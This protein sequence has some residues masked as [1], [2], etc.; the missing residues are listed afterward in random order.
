[1][2]RSSLL[3][4]AL[5]VALGTSGCQ[6]PNLTR[7]NFGRTAIVTGDFDTVRQLIQEVANTTT[8]EA[9]IHLFD[10]YIDGPH[11]ET[12]TDIEPGDLT[13]Q[14]EDLLRADTSQGL[15]QFD[16]TFLSCGMRGVS[17]HL[18]N[19][20][21]E[22]D[23]LVSDSTVLA[24]LQ[25]AL[26]HGGALYFSD[27]TYDLIQAA[28][29]DK[30]HWAGD[31]DELDDAQRGK[32]GA[33][34]A[35]VVSSELAAFM[36]LSVGDE[37]EIRFNQSGWAVPLSVADD[38]EVLI[39]ADIEYDNPV[40]GEYELREDVPLVFSFAGGGRVVYTAFHNEAQITDDAR[41]VLRFSLTRLSDAA[42]T[43]P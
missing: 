32:E 12:E 13:N 40:T 1:L 37:I 25:E 18:Y 33:V 42:S 14:V 9:D 36:E 39:E 15:D 6:D 38:V 35:R 43:S 4:A 19:G 3:I 27:W 30:V 7:L 21:A 10:G 29:P 31:E 2:R 24:N 16:T 23:H 34:N 28:W 22:D 11:F 20:V 17:D 5:A 26:S 8:V 41:D